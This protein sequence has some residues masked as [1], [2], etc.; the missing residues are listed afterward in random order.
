[1]ILFNPEEF[2][3]YKEQTV[4]IFNLGVYDVPYSMS[5]NGLFM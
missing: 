5:E 3:E 2:N 4:W 1:V